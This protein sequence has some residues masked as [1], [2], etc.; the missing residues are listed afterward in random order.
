MRIKY[1]NLT[2]LAISI[3]IGSLLAYFGVFDRLFGGLGALGYVG[4][5][6]VGMLFPITFTAPIATF[7]LFY[8]GEHFHV[9]A[10]TIIAAVGA[11][12]GDLAIF[13]FVR[14]RTLKEV[15]EIR[16]EYRIEHRTHD[17][18]RRHKA[19]VQLFHSKPF[20][21]LSLFIG[22]LVILSPI[23]DELGIAILASY[24]VHMKKFIPISLALNAVGIWLIVMAGH[25]F[26]N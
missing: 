13:T 24:K 18:Y 1:P 19:L 9:G 12:F 25:V 5:L 15:E 6:F 3:I 4:A 2:L 14:D 23:P 10:V 21:A 11:L 26:A 20:H 7:A 22:G 8:L 17:H 16:S